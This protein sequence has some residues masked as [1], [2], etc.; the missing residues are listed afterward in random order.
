MKRREKVAAVALVV[1]GVYSAWL[2]GRALTAPVV[3]QND[4]GQICS[5]V[6]NKEY[7]TKEQCELIDFEEDLFEA[8][9]VVEC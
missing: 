9:N 4:L 7:P 5:C 3:F 2:F 8:I 1:I 6:V